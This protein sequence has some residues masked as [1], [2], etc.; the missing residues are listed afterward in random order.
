MPYP[1]FDRFAVKMDP[2][3]TRTN[4]KFIDKDHV[5]IDASPGDLRRE[6]TIDTSVNASPKFPQTGG[7]DRRF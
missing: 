2:L 5:P 1:K 6:V 7:P 3:A 4:K